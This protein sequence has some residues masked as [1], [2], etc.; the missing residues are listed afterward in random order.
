MVSYYQMRKNNLPTREVEESFLLH[1]TGLSREEFFL[2]RP[3]LNPWQKIQYFWL[4]RKTT[5]GY[6]LQYLFKTAPFYGLN[7]F[8][9]KNVLIPRIETELLVE[10]AIRHLISNTK[11]YANKKKLHV[12]DVGT[13]S[14]CIT[15]SLFTKIKK[16]DPSCAKYADFY[17]VDVSLSA[18]KIAR[19]NAATHRAD[20]KFL[21]SN[22]LDNPELPK[23]FDLILANLPYL[24]SEYSQKLPKKLADSLKFE[25]CIALDGGRDGLDLI[26]RLLV[27]LPGR[28]DQNGLAILEIDPDQL[29][30]IEDEFDESLTIRSIRDLNGFD[31]FICVTNKNE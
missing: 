9:N 12:I 18:L 16:I 2:T 30:V 20:I 28:L 13:G 17:A 25:P 24:K 6:P 7:L 3:V 22:L 19:Q 23:K 4:K 5:K 1:L 31:R 11:R 8:V 21:E 27:Q 14:G 26:K 29:K 15:I 10:Q